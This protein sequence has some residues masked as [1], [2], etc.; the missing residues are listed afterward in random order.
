MAFNRK[1][2]LETAPFVIWMA[3]MMA[4]PATAFG[5]AVRTLVVALVLGVTVCVCWRELCL[6]PVT[7]RS[8]AWGIA[9]GLFIA[10]FWVFPE[11]FVWY[12]RFFVWGE[13]G[14]VAVADS[15]SALLAA[16][17]FGS[18]LVIAVAEELFFRKWLMGFAGFGW[19]VVLFAVEHDRWLVGALAGVVLGLL[20]LRKGLA[21]AVIAHVTANLALGL[22]VLRTGAWE[23][24]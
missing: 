22:W 13:G 11:S 9:S 19:S 6:W 15:S 8:A 14:T 23:L 1:L 21:C 24:W 16:R 10:A 3:L 12:H 18:C 20:Y 7:F 17:L 2:M 5:Y 4:L